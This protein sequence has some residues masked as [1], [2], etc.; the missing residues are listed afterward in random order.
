VTRQ[1]TGLVGT[2]DVTSRAGSGERQLIG[3]REREGWRV[4]VAFNEKGVVIGR[5]REEASWYGSGVREE[6]E[7]K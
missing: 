1:A 3:E 7:T 4:I 5:E 2:R 6:R